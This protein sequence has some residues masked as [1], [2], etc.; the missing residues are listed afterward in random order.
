MPARGGYNAADDLLERN[1]GAGRAAKVAFVDDDGSYTY[2]ELAAR[3]DRAASALL[4]LGLTPGDRLILGLL[5]SIDF[6]TCFLGAIK[7]GIVPVPVNTMFQSADYAFV[8]ENSGAAVA[9]VSEPLFAAYRAGADAIGWRGT[10]VATRGTEPGLATLRNLMTDVEPLGEAAAT[11][12]DD[13]AFWLYSSGSTGK[14]KGTL[15]RHASLLATAERFARDVLGLHE[16]DVIYSAA[17]LFFAYGLGN[18]LTFP[19]SVGASAV[20]RA[21]RPKPDAVNAVLVSHKPTIF[22]GV[23]TLYSALLAAGLPPRT[24]LALRVCTSAGEALPRHVGEAWRERTGVDIIDGIGST[25]MLHIFLS[26]R[27]GVVTYGVTGKPVPGYDVRLVDETGADAALGELGEL[28]VRGPSAFARYWNAPERT[29]RA[30][31]GDWVRTGDKFFQNGDGDYVHCGRTDDMLK[32]G[33]IWVS[34]SEVEGALMAHEAALEVAVI[35]AADEN[36]LM[37]PKAFVVLQ[38]G[39]TGD[40]SLVRELQVFVK[41][42][43]APYKFPRWIEFVDELPKTATGKIQRH[44]LRQREAAARAANVP[45]RV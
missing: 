8:L 21:A 12:A 9:I 44:L 36:D 6:P 43:L 15:H 13:V 2:G 11:S 1:L 7:A 24:E 4:A 27:P 23:P 5:D 18:A 40:A 31:A 29:A 19:M 3:V 22:C 10:F 17:K 38:A 35:G 37:K 39:R 16:N 42:R 20:L 45:Q 34:P 30:F 28:L 32:V 41:D 26:T 33:G 14:P 25:E